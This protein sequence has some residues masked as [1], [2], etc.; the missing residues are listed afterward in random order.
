MPALV[1]RSFVG[2]ALVLA[3]DLP[4]DGPP[5]PVYWSLVSLYNVLLMVTAR[6]SGLVGRLPVHCVRRSGDSPNT[7]RWAHN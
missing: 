5:S 3:D 1:L 2:Q 7:I 6:R 4:H